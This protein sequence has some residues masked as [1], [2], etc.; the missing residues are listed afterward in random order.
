MLLDTR[1]G[2]R[3]RL[4]C[5]FH[6]WTLLAGRPISSEVHT[7]VYKMCIGLSGHTATLTTPKFTL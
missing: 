6:K 5:A 2:L 4:R 3:V 1:S 7:R